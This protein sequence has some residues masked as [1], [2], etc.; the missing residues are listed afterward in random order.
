MF[1]DEYAARLEEFRHLP[2]HLSTIH[3]SLKRA[4]LSIKRVQKLAKERDPVL[5]ANF[6]H[7]IGQYN[8]LCLISIDEVSKDDRT[9]ARLWGRSPVGERAEQHDP[10]VRKRRFSMCAA[11]ALNEGII[12]SRVIK[13]S[14]THNSF[15]EYL[16]DD[17]LPTTTPYPGPRSVLILD[18]ARIH[19]SEEI[20]E[21]VHSFGC[22]I[23]YLPPY[24][25]DY[26]PIEQAFS[27]IKSYLRR[28]GLG[29]YTRETHYYELY[30][31]C[32]RITPEMTW[33]FFRH[34]GYV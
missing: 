22:R 4:G 33:G 19:H 9:Y 14:F 17:V 27:S 5:C 2:V 20:R 8:L 23:E 32:T 24:S 6:V 31:A 10:F 16:R 3:R 30:E 18:N 15:Y 11:M 25:P 12:A 28:I 29:F 26:Q 21:L 7:R 13:G 1:L 34:A